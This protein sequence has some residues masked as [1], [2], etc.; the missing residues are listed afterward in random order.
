MIHVSRQS[1][2]IRRVQ[3]SSAASAILKTTTGIT[4]TTIANATFFTDER[5]LNQSPSP[6][7][8]SPNAAVGPNG[9]RPLVMHARVVTSTGGGP[10]KT[11]LNSPRFLNDLG[12]DALCAFL[13]PPHDSGFESIRARAKEQSAP[14]IEIEDCSKFDWR[15]VRQI[16]KLCRDRNVAIWHAHDYKTN[17]IGLIAKRFHAM[18]LVT[19][20]HGWVNFSGHTPKYYRLDKRWFLPRYEKVICVS[21]TVLEEC[22]ASGVP[23]SRCVLIENAI[24]HEQFCRRRPIAEAKL[25]RFG[26][27]KDQLVIGSIGRLAEEKGFDLLIA[28]FTRVVKNGMDARLVIAGEGPDQE[29][30]KRVIAE[31]GVAD[32]IE[33]IGFC[34][35]TVGFLESLD[36]FVLS[37]H[38][39][40][41]PNV[42][43]EAMAVGTAVIATKVGGVGRLVDDGVNGRLIESGSMEQIAAALEELSRS[44]EMRVRFAENAVQTIAQHWSFRRRMEKVVNVYAG[45]L[46]LPD[47]AVTN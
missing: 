34:Q 13:R 30:L 38:R 1:T 5:E 40:G 35:D 45:V 8:R 26:A 28:A 4:C 7:T 15:A 9:R 14:L 16:V 44:I 20:A 27:T 2:I 39:E 23:G 32:R 22:L 17:L 11:I 12:Y 47:S 3:P 43:L 19:T 36:I 10:D 6:T 31:S 18:S 25:Q 41:L 21:S 42:V 37:S 29:I 46:G 33:L 24:D